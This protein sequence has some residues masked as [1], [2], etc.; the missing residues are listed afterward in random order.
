M[1]ILNRL[2]TYVLVS[3]KVNGSWEILGYPETEFLFS[4][5]SPK[6]QRGINIEGLIA[7]KNGF[8]N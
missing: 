6:A 5:F 8:G 3:S 4:K 2:S 1:H 7:I